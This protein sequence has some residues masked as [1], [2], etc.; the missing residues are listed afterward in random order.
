[1]GAA[2]PGDLRGH[3]TAR[4]TRSVSSRN[5]LWYAFYKGWFAGRAGRRRPQV[6]SMVEHAYM[7]DGYDI[8]RNTSQGLSNRA[9]GAAADDD[10]SESELPVEDQSEAA[11]GAAE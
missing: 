4:R 9:A 5:T 7:I 11:E 8:G 3:Q 2:R 10:Y 6:H 1:M